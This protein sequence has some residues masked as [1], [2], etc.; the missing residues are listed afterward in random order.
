MEIV[1][2]FETILIPDLPSRFGKVVI[3]RTAEP[4]FGLFSELPSPP[5]AMDFQA[6]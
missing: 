1:T 5:D 2:R 4:G 3:H 6:P